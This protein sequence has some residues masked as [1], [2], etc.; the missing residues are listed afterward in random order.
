MRLVPMC[1]VALLASL[2]GCAAQQVD[3]SQF[4]PAQRQ[5]ILQCRYEANAATAGMR[6]ASILGLEKAATQNQLFRQCVEAKEAALDTQ[7]TAP[8]APVADNNRGLPTNDADCRRKF[9]VDCLTW[10]H[11]HPL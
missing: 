4:T 7:Q 8:V 1:C 9:G 11:R 2:T 6:E 5:V 3:M 10:I